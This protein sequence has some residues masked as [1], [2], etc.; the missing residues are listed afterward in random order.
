[1]KFKKLISL[2]IAVSIALSV[3][4]IAV[5]A[6]SDENPDSSST[7]KTAETTAAATTTTAAADNTGT[8]TASAAS[9]TAKKTTKK[10]TKK[11][12][13]KKSTTSQT[14]I[15]DNPIPYP[16]AIYSSDIV[17]ENYITGDTF[18]IDEIKVLTDEASDGVAQTALDAVGVGADRALVYDIEITDGNGGELIAVEGNT[19]PISLEI[20]EAAGD[21]R[22]FVMY[23]IDEDGQAREVDINVTSET[24]E[25]STSEFGLYVLTWGSSV[26]D[27]GSTTDP[28]PLI[29][30]LIAALSSISSTVTILIMRKKRNSEQE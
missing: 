7:T 8:T 11:T 20:P 15:D 17:A 27:S 25:F 21:D 24:I 9:T 12:T 30:C 13:K 28:M 18:T 22:K 6:E 16:E 23:R 5:A 29:I 14:I 1:M 4:G 19:I 2:F 3:T 10:A 26:A